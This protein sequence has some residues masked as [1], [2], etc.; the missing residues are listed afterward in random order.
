MS[1]DLFADVPRGSFDALLPRCQIVELDEGNT[2]IERYGGAAWSPTVVKLL[3]A[4]MDVLAK[5]PSRRRQLSW[6]LPRAAR[7]VAVS[8]G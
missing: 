7:V 5:R 1:A 2:V 8:D 6:A 3:G 4:D